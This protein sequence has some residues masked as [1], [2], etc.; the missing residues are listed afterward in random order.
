MAPRSPPS[1]GLGDSAGQDLVPAMHPL[2]PQS[3]Q[4]CLG[5]PRKGLGL[6]PHREG[7]TVLLSL[8]LGPRVRTWLQLCGTRGPRLRPESLA[9][10]PQ[11]SPGSKCPH[12]PENQGDSFWA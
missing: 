7:G 10:S 9:T 2:C 3:Q 6:R 11:G 1:T 4:G 8:Q 5:P 12:S